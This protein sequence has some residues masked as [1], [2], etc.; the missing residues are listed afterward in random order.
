M[1]A[2]KVADRHGE[3]GAEVV[4]VS[5]AAFRGLGINAGHRVGEDDGQRAVTNG[6]VGNG[7]EA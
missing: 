5:E 4:V 7:T 1:N 3:L 6:R 2:K